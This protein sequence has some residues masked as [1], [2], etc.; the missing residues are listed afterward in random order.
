ML[1]KKKKIK[2]NKKN[3]SNATMD[4]EPESK[5]SKVADEESAS[6]RKPVP[7]V[8]IAL[9]G[10]VIANAQTPQLKAYLAGQLAR[11]VAI[12]RADEVVVYADS[13]RREVGTEDQHAVFLARILQYLETPQYL[14]KALFPMH[15]DLKNVGLTAPTDMPHH[16]REGEWCRYRE[17]IVIKRPVK[18]G[19]Q[20]SWV[21]VGLNKDAA[22]DAAVQPGVRVTVEI[23]EA[24][25]DAKTLRGTAVAPSVPRCKEGLYW[26]YQVRLAQNLGAV[27]SECPFGQ[28]DLSVGTSQHGTN[29]VEDRE[30]RLPEFKHMI[31]VSIL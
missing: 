31:V 2:K 22:I 7:T 5:K 3:K 19:A 28:Y 27:W 14:R 9:P 15:P 20:V 29:V 12:F 24:S 17:G 25:K 16:L 10:S 4:G 11:A 23:D 18:A 13:A 30:W 8:S 1:Q 6:E 26:G 21:N